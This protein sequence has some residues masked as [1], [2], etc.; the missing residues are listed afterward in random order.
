MPQWVVD[1]AQNLTCQA[2][3]DAKRGEQLVL[4]ISVGTKPQPWQFVGIDV[5]RV[6]FYE[7]KVK[8]R[9]LIMIDLTT[10]CKAVEVLW[11]G[12]MNEAGTEPGVRF[13]EVFASAWLQHRP[14]PE[15]VLCSDQ[16]GLW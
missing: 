8:A 7:L 10:R 13:M 16:P 4:P 14:R 11:S 3:I 5:V 2:C 12:K 15:W 9:Y 6:P 1:E